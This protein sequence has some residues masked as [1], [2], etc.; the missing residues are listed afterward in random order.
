MRHLIQIALSTGEGLQGLDVYG[1]PST[2]SIG[3]N[4]NITF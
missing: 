1:M 2:R 4:L 3:L